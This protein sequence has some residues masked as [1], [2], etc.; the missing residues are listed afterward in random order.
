MRIDEQ[1]VLTE[2]GATRWKGGLGARPS[3]ADRPAADSPCGQVREEGGR[4]IW[5]RAC[6]MKPDETA[7]S[8]KRS[9]RVAHE[10]RA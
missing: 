3:A 8:V 4:A 6:G 7:S 5:A 9:S 1:V 10:G 2:G